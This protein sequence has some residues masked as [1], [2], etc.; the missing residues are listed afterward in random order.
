MKFMFALLI[1][2]LNQ[3]KNLMTCSNDGLRIGKE[4]KT[5]PVARD[6]R[7]SAELILCKAYVQHRTGTEHDYKSFAS[8]DIY[9]VAMFAQQL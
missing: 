6:F 5:F 9:Y 4:L 3:H 8:S 2:A 1:S 7:G